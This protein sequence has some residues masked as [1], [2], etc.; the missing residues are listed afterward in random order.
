MIK[1]LII[2]DFI[3]NIGEITYYDLPTQYHVPF[4]CRHNPGAWRSCTT[5]IDKYNIQYITPHFEL[6]EDQDL[7]KQYLNNKGS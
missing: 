2:K 3:K 1:I 5:F 6:E 7:F 4:I